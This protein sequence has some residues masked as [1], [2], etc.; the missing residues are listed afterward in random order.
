MAL[1]D[2]KLNVWEIKKLTVWQF[3]FDFSTFLF[4]IL[5]YLFDYFLCSNFLSFLFFCSLNCS[6]PIKCSFCHFQSKDSH[7]WK[8]VDKLLQ[9]IQWPNSRNFK[10][11][12]S[13]SHTHTHT[14]TLLW[15]V[16]PC[17]NIDRKI[18]TSVTQQSENYTYRT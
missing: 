1:C 6:W 8:I 3:Y 13:L 18:P 9:E 10:L 7:P 14:H 16:D 2:I 17:C 4:F 5:P 15:N 12:L 11:S